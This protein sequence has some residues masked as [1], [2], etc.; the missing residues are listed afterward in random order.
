MID[1]L[2]R[3]GLLSIAKRQQLDNMVSTL[4][5]YTAWMEEALVVAE[6]SQFFAPAYIKKLAA[7]KDNLAS[8]QLRRRGTLRTI[9]N[10]AR[11]ILNDMRLLKWTR[12]P[13]SLHTSVKFWNWHVVIHLK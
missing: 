5:N 10:T 3:A 9:R 8:S 11:W 7:V 12:R 13:K 2:K 1:R 4:L 6:E